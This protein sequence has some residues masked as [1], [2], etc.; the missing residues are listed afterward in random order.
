MSAVNNPTPRDN[1]LAA[2]IAGGENQTVE[3]KSWIKAC[4]K[5]ERV[6]LAVEELIAFANS[7]G[8]TLYFGIEDDG[9]VTGCT[10]YNC[11]TLIEAIYDK[12]R[13]PLFV[14]IKEIPYQKHIVLA[15]SVVHDGN[16]YATTDGK[17]LKRLGKSSKPYYPE[18]MSS[19]YFSSQNPD[20]S[21][22]LISDGKRCGFSKRY[23]LVLV[24][25]RHLT[26]TKT[27]CRKMFLSLIAPL[28]TIR[29]NRGKRSN[30]LPYIFAQGQER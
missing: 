7:K 26:C 9:E 15:L 4:R 3:F 12:T 21:A 28:T 24:A 13:P 22:Q 27:E 14:E 29:L 11:Q 19:R 17:C 23:F 20:F 2:I 18:E 25:C 1:K 16:T 5:G 8:G 30:R 6:N 10:N